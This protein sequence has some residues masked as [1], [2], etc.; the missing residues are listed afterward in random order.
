MQSGGFV[1]PQE[2]VVAAKVHPSP[3]L[4]VHRLAQEM[5]RLDAQLRSSLPEVGEVF[6]DLTQ[7]RSRDSRG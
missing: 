6:I 1:A 4:S 2:V 7:H 5:D 3:H